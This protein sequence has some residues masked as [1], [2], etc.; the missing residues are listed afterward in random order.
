VSWHPLGAVAPDAL[1]NARL[2]LHHAAQVVASAGA[3]F[4]EARPDDSHPNLGWSE[5]HGA[6]L[7]RA[8]PATGVQ[9]GLL[10]AAPALLLL[11][12]TGRVVEEIPLEGHTLE[13][14]YAWLAEATAYAGEKLP[15]GGVVRAVYELP[16][17]PVAEGASFT[18]APAAPFEE[19]AAWFADGQQALAALAAKLPGASD[20][21]VWP[22]HFDLGALE[23]LETGPDGAVA[24][25]IG[26]GLSPGDEGYAE[27]YFYVSPWPY[28]AAGA[29]PELEGGGHWHVEGHTSAVL[30]GSA[31]LEGPAGGQAERLGRFLA[32]AVD[33]SRRAL[34]G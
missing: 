32:A 11:D 24:R 7:G 2:Q 15:A 33:A 4:L 18:T 19:L 9:V 13:E 22:H 25:S 28:P 14:A 10:V 12:A 5:A 23:V 20:L 8:L 17:H 21:R 6:L 16:A 34:S 26:V 31:L 3:T 27:P 1:V 30:T 29:L